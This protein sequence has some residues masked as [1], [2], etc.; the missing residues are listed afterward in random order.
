MSTTI[1][2]FVP[3]PAVVEWMVSEP[4]TQCNIKFLNLLVYN[5]QLKALTV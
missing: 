5:P 4:L 2:E 3:E 1:E